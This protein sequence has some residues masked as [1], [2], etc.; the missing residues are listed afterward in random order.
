MNGRHFATTAR[1]HLTACLMM[2]LVGGAL[3][4]HETWLA[5]QAFTINAQQPL[6]LDLTS[7]MQFPE[8]EHPI[9][10]DRVE[11]AFLRIG[12][13]EQPITAMVAQSKALRLTAEVRNEGLAAI[14]VVLHPR[15]LTLT[16]D[17]VDEYFAEIQATQAV[18]AAWAKQK[19]RIPWKE[20]YTK[21]AKTFVASGAIRP[22]DAWQKPLGLDLELIPM[23]QPL[24]WRAGEQATFTLLAHGKPLQGLSVGL[25]QRNS[26]KPI[27]QT[28]NDHGQVTMTLHSEGTTLLYAVHLQPHQDG[29]RWVSAFTTLTILVQ[30]KKAN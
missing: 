18:R 7:G 4:G 17:Q 19:G 24:A 8:L 29:S 20:T 10:S 27:F 22:D 16:D 21:N 25:R 6:Q 30:P 15:S 5:P 9:R 14:G 3:W 12:A 13:T 26:S 23:A 1:W 11:R 2:L 28:T